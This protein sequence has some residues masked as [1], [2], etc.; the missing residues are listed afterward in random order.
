M[1]AHTLHAKNCLILI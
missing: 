1:N